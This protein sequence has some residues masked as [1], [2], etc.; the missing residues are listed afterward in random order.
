MTETVHIG[1]QVPL[2]L[3]DRFRA[4]AETNDRKV[5]AELR[6]AVKEYVERQEAEV[7]EEDTAA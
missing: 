3:A 2:D 1:G 7:D 4:I 6:V 5:A